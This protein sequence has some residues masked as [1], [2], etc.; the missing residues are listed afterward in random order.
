MSNTVIDDQPAPPDQTLRREIDA[1]P[2]AGAEERVVELAFASE[3]PVKR[4]DYVRD[5][6]YYE[7]LSC[8]PEDVDLSRLN[9]GHPLLLNHDTGAQIGVVLEA[10]VDPDKMC[11]ARVKFSR[12][13]LGE[14]IWLDVREGIRRLVSVGYRTV[15]EVGRIETDGVETVRFAW[16]PYEISLVPVPADPSC[17]VGRSENFDDGKKKVITMS[18]MVVPEPQPGNKSAEMSYQKEAAEILAV[19]KNLRGKIEAID[20]LAGQAISA[21]KSLADFRAMALS[22][23]PEVK[24]LTKPLLDDVKPKEWA[25]YSLSKAI[26]EASDSKL[27][28]LERE[29]SD[30]LSLRTGQK[31]QGFWVP[32]RALSERNYVAGGVTVTSNTLGG[33]L[34]LAEPMADEFVEILRNRAAVV[35]MGARMLTLGGPVTI[36]RQYAAGSANWVGETVASTLSTGGVQQITLVPNA[37]SA[38]QQYSKQ[39]LYTSNPSIDALVR[40]D[41]T[42]IIALAIDRAALHGTGSG[43]PLGIA[44]T[45]GVNTV[46]VAMIA[47]GGLGT[48]LYPFLVSLESEVASDNADIGALGYIMRPKERG[49]CKVI[50]RF[51]S[52]DTPV[53]EPGNAVNGYP[54]GV[55]NQ[56][57]NNLTTGT[58]TT[59]CT[60]IFFGNWN[61][62][63]IAQFNGGATDLV[64]DPYTYAHNG[65]VRLCARRWVDI[66]VRH[67]ESFC[68]G[69]GIL[70]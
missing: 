56:I 3:M 65:V 27:S 41:I 61:D 33:A 16:Q 46:S 70:A 25:R 21:G 19:A 40:D 36:P 63:L 60:A 24:P 18:E 38:Y 58:A 39:L 37:I 49:A 44:A 52:G 11:R 64:V 8:A 34:A 15:K 45:T 69:G 53:W 31:P 62:L 22:K 43:Q 6:E 30:E 12:S 67:P 68:V 28:G 14:E 20:E 55:T 48:S 50:P 23:L 29:L 59:I 1:A 57:A 2:T 42:Q 32:G 4:Y 66:G 51:S 17:G 35:A 10:R 54:V 9:N 47:A 26:V 13:K 5:G 7:V